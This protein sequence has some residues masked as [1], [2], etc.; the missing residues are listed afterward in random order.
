MHGRPKKR[1]NR[2]FYE[3]KK[4]GKMSR[5][6]VYMTCSICHGQNH[7]MR[8]LLD[9]VFLMLDQV[10]YQVLQ[11]LGGG[12]E[13]P[14]PQAAARERE[15]GVE[16]AVVAARERE[17]GV[18]HAAAAAKGREMGVEHDAAIALAGRGRGRPRKTPL[19]DI[20]M[21]RRTPLHEWFENQ[22][23]YAPPNPPASPVYAPPNSFASPVH[24]PPNPHV[25]T[26]KR[27]KTVGI[28]VLIAE[29]GFTT[30]NVSD[31]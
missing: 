9:Q 12:Q 30:Y 21:A 14:L 23:S 6:G 19:G 20:G 28:G 29:N 17:R 31:D 1:R 26:G 16:H 18:E 24:T 22:T 10:M 2:Q 8:I 4:C 11:D 25:S 5:K 7:N 13:T 27:P 3:T 15:R